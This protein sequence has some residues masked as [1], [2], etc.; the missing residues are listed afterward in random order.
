MIRVYRYGVAGDAESSW[1]IIPERARRVLRP[2][3]ESRFKVIEP[4][5]GQTLA[6]ATAN[7]R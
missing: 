6:T 4:E 7:E 3:L 1:P 2:A 5:D